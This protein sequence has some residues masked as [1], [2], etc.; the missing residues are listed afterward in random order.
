MRPTRK[1]R[2]TGAGGRLCGPWSRH[3]RSTRL[4]L[5]EVSGLA[6]DVPG[7]RLLHDVNLAAQAGECLAVVGPSGSGKTSLLNCLCGIAR[8]TSGSVLVDGVELTGLGLSAQTEFRLRRVGMVFQ[9]GELLPELTVLENVA[10]P[11]RLLGI[12]RSQAERRA[13]A[14]LARLG[15]DGCG[16]AHPNAL[17]GGEVQ[18]AGIAR[19]LAHEPRLVLADEPTGALDED[20]SAH[21]AGLLVGAAKESGAMV[22]VATHDPLIASK[23]DRVLRLRDGHLTPVE[24][25]N[26]SEW[27]RA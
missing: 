25:M 9:F 2:L 16:E 18:R 27:G 22:I 14:W 24:G 11:L 8:P 1:Q 20:N 13:T 4:N 26:G 5:L 7:R 3:K 6:L 23:A 21:I 17:S 19:A 12:S 10:L 15:L